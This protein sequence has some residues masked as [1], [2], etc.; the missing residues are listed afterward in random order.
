M[1]IRRF[2]ILT[3]LLF[4]SFLLWSAWQSDHSVN[5]ITET[6]STLTNPSATNL[7]SNLS[8]SLSSNL[9]SPE[10][11]IKNLNSKNRYIHVHTDVLEVIIDRIDG[12][13]IN[14]KLLAYPVSTD[15]PNDPFVLLNDNS[16]TYY[17]AQS[18][19]VSPDIHQPIIYQS[20]KDNYTITPGEKNL[21]VNLTWNNNGLIINKTYN[22]TAKDYTVNVSFNVINQSKSNWQGQISAELQRKKITPRGMGPFNFN[23]YLGAAISSPEKR[24]EQIS[25][26]KMDQAVLN[27]NIQNGWLAMEQHYFITAWI[28]DTSTSY[29]YYTQALPNDV[30]T[31]GL[32]GPAV[33]LSPN[34]QASFNTKLYVGPKITDKLEAAAPGLDLTIDYGILWFISVAIFSLMKKIHAFT[35]NWG[36][37]IVLVTLTIKLVFYK[38]NSIS[39]RSMAA[40]RNLQPKLQTL[41]ERY[42]DDRQKL[43]QATME[44]YRKER[45]NPLGGC[46]P[47]IVQ[48]PV[49]LALYWVLVESVELRQAPFV[50]WIKDLSLK[51]PY[52]ILPLLMGLTLLI[53]Q[54]LNPKP[55][56]PIQQ[57][58]MMLMPIIFTALFLNFPAGLVLYWV[59]N[60]SLSILQQW[61]IMKHV[62]PKVAKKNKQI[63]K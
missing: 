16:D 49:F 55:P 37:S 6:T 12:N 63:K 56:D 47:L 32:I 33:D 36:W 41:K 11:D 17:V 1:D 7:A 59:V 30:Y 28:P 31:I 35:G 13:I 26:K 43:T 45:I 27:K 44:L 19:I 8:T 15:K 39:F 57:K 3:T 50:F 38:L 40:M 42:G 51:D 4:I 48:I 52:Y 25:F 14:S 23:T 20:S 18:N 22:F 9:A 61:Y 21:S 5:V 2:F 62:V 24:Y 54:W 53:Q 58:V 60:N 46:L 29:H 34:N 10:I